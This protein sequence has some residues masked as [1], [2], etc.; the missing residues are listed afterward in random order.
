MDKKMKFEEFTQAVV[1]KI[2]EYLPIGFANAAIELQT[3]VK[4]N[5]MKLTGLTI[6]SVDSNI[7]PT[8]YLE[9]FYDRYKDGADISK[10]LE[11]IAD[12]R[13][14]HELKE[15]FDIEQITD[16][17]RVK[18]RIC[19]KLIN[20]GWNEALLSDRPYTEVADLAVIY[21]V[22]LRQD[23]DGA[24]TVTVTNQ[25]MNEWNTT[26]DELH[27]LAVRNM[28]NLNPNSVQPMSAVLGEMLGDTETNSL[29]EKMPENEIMFVITNKNKIN[30]ATAVLDSSFMRNI[31]DNFG[32]FLLIPSS[33]HEWILVRDTKDMDV[34]SISAM[35]NEVN[36]EQVA[37]DDRLSDHPYRYSS[38]EG[39][40][41]V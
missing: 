14:R 5:D 26:V 22:M 2:R 4:N 1:D 39:L 8:I 29:I 10:V 7:S 17:E 21:Q 32:S 20:R 19:P 31:V 40:L 12:I 34:Q 16:F 33:I 36:A 35:I 27:E 18:D 9:N 23:F 28:T 6:R 13:I 41:P 15:S 25:L 3:I 30:A 11:D 24:A 37:V 38:E